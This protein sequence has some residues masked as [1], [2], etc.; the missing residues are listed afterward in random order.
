MDVITTIIAVLK[1]SSM[2]LCAKLARDC[3]RGVYRLP[4]HTLRLNQS[5]THIPLFYDK[6][7]DG[8]D[9]SEDIG[10]DTRTGEGADAGAKAEMVYELTG[11]PSSL[12][13]SH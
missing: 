2:S 11:H 12:L 6:R 5:L 1:N 9:V 13:H 3:S 10:A 8:E 7:P 4:W